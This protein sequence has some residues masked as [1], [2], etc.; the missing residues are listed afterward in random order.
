MF[1]AKDIMTSH[2]V[3]VHADDTV[4]RAITLMVKHRISGLPVLDKEGRL[5]GVVSEFDLLELICE[6][7]TEND[8][9]RCTC[10]RRCAA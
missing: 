1:H 6:G 3:A 7:Q 5:V 2:V 10:P 4:D 9:A 8:K